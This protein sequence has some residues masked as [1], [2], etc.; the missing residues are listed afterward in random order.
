[1]KITLAQYAE[2][3]EWADRIAVAANRM[4]VCGGEKEKIVL[5]ALIKEYEKRFDDLSFKSQQYIAGI[6]KI[7]EAMAKKESD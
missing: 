4:L 6:L 3:T 5:R 1:M 7:T 2:L